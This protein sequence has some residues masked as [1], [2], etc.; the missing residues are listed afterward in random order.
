MLYLWG[1]HIVKF[2]TVFALCLFCEIF[3]HDI[4]SRYHFKLYSVIFKI[5]PVKFKTCKVLKM[6]V[7]WS[8]LELFWAKIFWVI[9]LPYNEIKA[10]LRHGDLELI[11]FVYW[12]FS[13]TWHFII[14]FNPQEHGWF[15]GVDLY[16][17]KAFS[18][19]PFHM[20][21]YLLYI[22]DVIWDSVYTIRY[23]DI[24]SA[25]RMQTRLL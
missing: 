6:E 13:L 8:F 15:W 10:F 21:F 18:L 1:I 23:R 17:K 5:V 19:I 3:S 4:L 9:H 7:F 14:K 20:R 16:A 12:I 2:C 25:L 22:D 11:C 24:N